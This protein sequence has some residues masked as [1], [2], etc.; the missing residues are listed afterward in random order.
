MDTLLQFTFFM[1]GTFGSSPY[2]FLSL[3]WEDLRYQLTLTVD[4]RMEQLF[5]VLR[6]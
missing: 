2:V 5:G 4:S 3:L 1:W 6:L